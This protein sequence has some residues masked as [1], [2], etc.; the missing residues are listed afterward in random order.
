MVLPEVTQD[1][2]VKI[3]K[4]G[5]RLVRSDPASAANWVSQFPDGNL[6]MDATLTVIV[7]WSRQDSASAAAR[8]DSIGGN[9]QTSRERLAPTWLARIRRPLKGGSQTRRFPDA[10]NQRLLGHQRGNF[11]IGCSFH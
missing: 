7:S 2:T 8:L 10:T 3:K 9:Q 4:C 5:G 6:R 1:S 11:I